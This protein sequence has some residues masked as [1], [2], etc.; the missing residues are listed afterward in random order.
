MTLLRTGAALAACYAIFQVVF[1]PIV[2]AFI[3]IP[4]LHYVA[5]HWPHQ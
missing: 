3:T 5:A 2:W 1:G 4:V